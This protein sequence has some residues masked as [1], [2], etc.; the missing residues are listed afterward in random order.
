[1]PAAA[2]EQALWHAKLIVAGMEKNE[3]ITLDYSPE[4]VRHLDTLLTTFHKKGFTAER[5]PKIF[6]QI[7]CYIGQVVVTACPKSK[8]MH[9]EDFDP[10]LDSADFPDPVIAHPDNV[11]WAPM[12]RAVK[13]LD[14]PE[15]N[16]LLASC[17]GEI[18]RYRSSRETPVGEH[19][20]S[21]I[22]WWEF[23]K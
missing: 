6:F 23:W 10:P 12:T 4:S 19:S 9:A 14:D 11:I 16:S 15:N 8:W 5:V 20:R 2:A 21:E 18:E 22:R 17:L 7:G 3:G 13:V 1:M